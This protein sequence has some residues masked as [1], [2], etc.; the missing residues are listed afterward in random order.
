MPKLNFD[1]TQF[2][3]KQNAL[4]LLKYHNDPIETAEFPAPIAGFSG[5]TPSYRSTIHE[6]R[7]IRSLVRCLNSPTKPTTVMGY[8]S[9]VNRLPG[10]KRP[11]TASASPRSKTTSEKT[12]KNKASKEISE[13]K[14]AQS[15]PLL[16][17]QDRDP[18][19]ERGDSEQMCQEKRKSPVLSPKPSLDR[20]TAFLEEPDRPIVSRISMASAGS[21]DTVRKELLKASKLNSDRTITKTHDRSQSTASTVSQRPISRIPVSRYPTGYAQTL[22]GSSFWYMWPDEPSS[23]ILPPT[24]PE[25][26][27]ED[28]RLNRNHNVIYHKH[29]GVVPKYMGYVPGYKFRHGSTYGV[30]TSHATSYGAV[31]KQGIKSQ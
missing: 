11:S 13:I 30:L 4:Y 18:K 16:T 6:Q 14:R 27:A 22:Y 19:V 21:S 25:S 26:Y 9:E 24:R 28:R 10:L 1:Y 5:H 29:E 2:L 8:Q 17:R 12:S 23:N 7:M 20:R 15:A 31:Y 3:K